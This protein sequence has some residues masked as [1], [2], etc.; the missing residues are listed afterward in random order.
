MS[1]LQSIFSVIRDELRK[2]I[3]NPARLKNLARP[4]K[5]GRFLS[6]NRVA[7][8]AKGEW[9]K[10]ARSGLSQRD[11]SDYE[12]YIQ[13]QSSKLE[14][15]DLESHEVRFRE[16]LKSRLEDLD[17]VGRAQSVVCLG[18]RLG[19]EVRSFLDLGWLYR[20]VGSN[21]SLTQ[22]PTSANANVVTKM[23]NAGMPSV[24]S[25][26]RSNRSAADARF[27]AMTS[28]FCA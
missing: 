20:L 27:V 5:I 9:N 3:A 11:Y 6:Y 4:D 13:V 14:Y 17:F 12:D 15:L 28:A 21:W 24:M 1:K 8:K 16:A 22:S 26:P 18:A 10:S 2:T 25:T 7:I 23:T 19:A